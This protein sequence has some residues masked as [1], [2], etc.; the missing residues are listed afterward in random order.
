LIA[1]V[2]SKKTDVAYRNK[3]EAVNQAE[4]GMTGHADDNNMTDC[5]KLT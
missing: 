1:A 5:M 2:F 3:K 4:D